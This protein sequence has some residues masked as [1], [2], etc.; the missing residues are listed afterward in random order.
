MVVVF[1]L[2]S[3]LGLELVLWCEDLVMQQNEDE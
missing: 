3:V 1:V 2:A